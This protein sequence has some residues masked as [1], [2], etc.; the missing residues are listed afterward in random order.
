ML[1]SV[2]ETNTAESEERRRIERRM[3]A[4]Q[5]AGA[6]VLTFS[7][8]RVNAL[9][10]RDI[11]NESLA[12]EATAVLTEA[13]NTYQ[14]AIAEMPAVEPK[15]PADRLTHVGF[16]ETEAPV[17]ANG[18]SPARAYTYHSYDPYQALN[19]GH[20]KATADFID[21][22][23]DQINKLRITHDPKLTYL[24][25]DRAKNESTLVTEIVKNMDPGID[26]WVSELPAAEGLRPVAKPWNNEP[27]IVMDET[28][29]IIDLPQ[30]A[31][32][33]AFVGGGGDG[34]A[35]REREAWERSM[36]RGILQQAELPDRTLTITSLGTGT[37]EPAMDTALEV[38]KAA[39]QDGDYAVVVNGFDISGRSLAIAQDIANRKNV[40][41]NLAFK[42]RRANILSAKGIEQAVGTTGA[43]VIE[44]IGLSEYVPSDG[45][46]TQ[47]EHD[48]REEM[49]A[50]RCLSAQEFYA[51][52]YAN[53]PE[54]SVFLTGN[55]RDDSP[56][57][58][59][60]TD[61]LGWPGIIRRSTED[62]MRILEESGIPG[63]AVRLYMPD[64]NDSAA[65]YNMVAITKLPTGAAK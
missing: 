41:E 64:K 12:A 45:A 26:A 21:I 32:L 13:A 18:W 9:N 59:F 50:K 43:N 52:I 46:P 53:M 65:V 27:I 39:Y 62:Y 34:R 23:K 58:D 55:M 51:T 16:S 22:A 24:G 63:E 40:P 31:A 2:E 38:M 47:E 10:R 20:V 57:G 11:S 8:R 14:A 37:G 61:G 7:D 19:P 36:M 44:A 5:S 6:V 35:V 25:T 33:R 3:A 42:P 1:Q 56:Q 28:G 60:I 49:K 48:K 54:G 17:T 15:N 4:G 29:K 30:T